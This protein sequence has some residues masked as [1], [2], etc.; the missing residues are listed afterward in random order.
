MLDPFDRSLFSIPVPNFRN[1]QEES[2]WVHSLTGQQRIELLE[3]VRLARYGAEALSRPIE[4]TMQCMTLAEFSKL[5][6]KEDRA[7]A[8][9]RKDHSWPPLWPRKRKGHDR[10][11]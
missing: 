6:E 4:R 3:L 10:S 5:K 7:E 11:T 9:W 1:E 2:N 8:K